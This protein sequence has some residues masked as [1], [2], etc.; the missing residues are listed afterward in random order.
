MPNHCSNTLVLPKKAMSVIVE[1][2]VGMERNGERVFD[3][4]RIAPV[5]EVPDWYERCIEKWGTKWLGYDLC[6]GET[7]LQFLT[8][9]S[10]PIPII[11]KLAELHKDTEFRLE[12]HEPG[13]GFCGVATAKWQ[14]GEVVINDECRDMTNED[15][16]KFG[17]M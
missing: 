7:S 11:G 15:F 13:M 6:V 9:W 12:Y 8:A 3:F 16:E 5:G 4:E 2:Y 10:P 1:K 14:D 17:F